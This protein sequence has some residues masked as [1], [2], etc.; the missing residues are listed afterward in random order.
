MILK[1][2]NKEPFSRYCAAKY[3]HVSHFACPS[4]KGYF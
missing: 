3:L 4:K 1:F 2:R